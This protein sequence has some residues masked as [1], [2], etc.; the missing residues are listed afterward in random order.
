M[1]LP[2]LPDIFGNY[3]VRGI[4]EIL[5]PD[6]VNWL[7]TTVG[8]KL[9]LLILL[10]WLGRTLWRQWQHW[11]CNRYRRAALAELEHIV[12][13]QP[14]A[15]HQLDAIA[16]LLKSTALHAYPRTEVATLSGPQWIT[17]LNAHAPQPLFSGP[18]TRL[19]TQSIYNGDTG[20]DSGDVEQLGDLAA[21]WI[22][23]HEAPAHA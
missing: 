4:A 19:L 22:R 18:A 12:S 20:I 6:R 3:A 21:T 11:R 13:E 14:D 7:P 23:R 9:S 16:R 1:G 10:G 5:P 17:W 8:W 15:R 2:P